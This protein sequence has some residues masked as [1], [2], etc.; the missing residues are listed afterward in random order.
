MLA[1]VEAQGQ[2]RLWFPLDPNLSPDEATIVSVFDHSVLCTQGRC[3]YDYDS[4]SRIIDAWGEE[5]RPT[6]GTVCQDCYEGEHAQAFLANGHYCGTAE[7]GDATI[8]RQHLCYNGHPGIDYRST[9]Y[10]H[11][12]GYGSPVYAAASGTLHTDALANGGYNGNYHEV[13]IDHGSGLA[14]IYLHMTN[15]TVEPGHV[16][17]GQQIGVTGDAGAPGAPHLHF[18]VRRFV[19]GHGW[20]PVDPYGWQG[21][22]S[23]PYTRATNEYLWDNLKGRV[24]WHPSGTLVKQAASP[25]IYVIEGTHLRHIPNMD[26][27]NGN[28]YAT[29]QIV[30]ISTAEYEA[31]TSGASGCGIGADVSL[32]AFDAFFTIAGDNFNNHYLARNGSRLNVASPAIA[33][34]WGYDWGSAQVVQPGCALASLPW[35]GSISFRDGALLESPTH[36]K[37]AV[38]HGKLRQFESDAVYDAMGYR[39]SSAIQAT[40]SEIEWGQGCFDEQGEVITEALIQA[41]P[42]CNGDDI[43][44]VAMVCANAQAEPHQMLAVPFSARDNGTLRRVFLQVSSLA[45]QFWRTMANLSPFVA[46]TEVNGSYDWTVPDTLNGA[47]SIRLVAE[48][49][50]GNLNVAYTTEIMITGTPGSP[51]VP[52]LNDPGFYSLNPDYTIDWSNANNV[53]YYVLEEDDN[54]S[55]SSPAQVTTSASEYTFYN[56]PNGDFWFRVKAVNNN[57]ESGWSN[58]IDFGWHVNHPPWSPSQPSPAHAATGFSR[59]HVV[60]SWTGSDPDNDALQYQPWFGVSAN[61]LYPTGPFGDATTHAVMDSLSGGSTYYWQVKAWDPYGSGTIAT[62][63]LWSFTTAYEFPDYQ[64]SNCSYTGTFGRRDSITMSV[65]V[66]NIGNFDAPGGSVYWYWSQD[67]ASNGTALYP[68]WTVFPALA[69]GQSVVV[70]QT[71]RLPEVTVG[72]SYLIAVV[73]VQGVVEPVLTN[74]RALDEVNWVDTN[75]PLV[76]FEG[77][78]YWSWGHMPGYSPLWFQAGQTY[79]PSGQASD[80]AGIARFRW[81]FSRDNGITWHTVRPWEETP[82]PYNDDVSLHFDWTPAVADTTDAGRLKVVVIDVSGDS[83][84]LVSDSVHVLY[85]ANPSVTILSPNGGEVWRVGETHTLQWTAQ[86]WV[87]ASLHYSNTGVGSPQYMTIASLVLPPAT[88]YQ[89]TVPG[90]ASGDSIAVHISIDGHGGQAA[91]WSDGTF[92]ILPN[93][94]QFPSPWSPSAVL[95]SGVGG[96]SRVAM[97]RDTDGTLHLVYTRGTGYTLRYLKRSPAGNWSSETTLDSLGDSPTLVLPSPGHPMVVYDY[98]DYN[99]SMRYVRA[100]YFDGS[101]WQAPVSLDSQPALNYVQAVATAS[102]DVWAA[103][104]VSGYA[105]GRVGAARWSGG[106]WGATEQVGAFPSVAGVRIQ[107]L[108]QSPKILFAYQSPDSTTAGHGLATVSRIGGLWTSAAFI[109]GMASGYYVDGGYLFDYLI[110]ADSAE[111]LVCTRSLGG[112]QAQYRVRTGGIWGSI[113]PL[114]GTIYYGPLALDSRGWPSLLQNDRLTWRRRD[115][116]TWG[117]AV[118]LTANSNVGTRLGYVI[119]PDDSAY[120]AYNDPVEN[121]L[122]FSA[123]H[124]SSDFTPPQVSLLAPTGGEIKAMGCTD[125]VRWTASDNIGI[126]G[127]D[128]YLSTNSGRN[129]T[130]LAASAANTGSQSWIVPAVSSDSCLMKLIVHDTGG[131]TGTALSP[132]VFAIHDLSAPT[133]EFLAPDGG[134]HWVIGQADTIRWTASDNYTPV[135]SLSCDVLLRRTPS[136]DPEILTAGAHT[137]FVLLWTATGAPSPNARVVVR[138]RDRQG[139]E[140]T[141]SS[142]TYL[143]IMPANAAPL[144]PFAPVPVHASSNVM[145]PA[146][147]SW[148]GTDPDADHLSYHVWAGTDSINLTHVAGPTDSTSWASQGIPEGTTYFWRIEVHDPYHTVLGPIWKFTMASVLAGP[149]SLRGWPLGT[150]Q[151]RLAWRNHPTSA[152]MTVVEDRSDSL[153]VIAGVTS[154]DSS[155]LT[156]DNLPPNTRHIYRVYASNGV[157]LSPSSNEVVV[158]TG[159][160]PPRVPARPHPLNGTTNQPLDLTLRYSGGDEDPGDQVH[161]RLQFGTSSVP[162]VIDTALVDTFKAVS[163]LQNSR[164]IFWRVT[165]I[166]NQGAQTS[167][168]LWYFSTTS[169]T[170]PSAP[171]SVTAAIQSSTVV[172]INWTDVSQ[173]ESG[174]VIQRQD[175]ES[176]PFLDIGAVPANTVSLMDST[177][178]G[179]RAY[180]YR[181]GSWNS[182]GRSV[183]SAPVSAITPNT[184]PEIDPLPDTTVLVGEMFEWT[185]GAYD[186]DLDTLMF[187]DN[188]AM[189]DVEPSTGWIQFTPALSD[190]GIHNVLVSATDGHGGVMSSAATWTVL[191]VAAP[192]AV[193]DVVVTMQPDSVRLDWSPVLTDTSGNPI[194]DISYV[195]EMSTDFVGWSTV[196]SADTSNYALGR[197]NLPAKAFFRVRAVRTNRQREQALRSQSAPPT[198]VEPHQTNRE[199]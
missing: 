10:G 156:L 149:D 72:T 176:A 100:R 109:P 68:R 40:Q 185:V 160:T 187:T 135:D 121:C 30:T 142:Q 198:R 133:V 57:G 54:A 161:Y 5:A 97:A 24:A 174:F 171:Q 81:D 99:H 88:S 163:G 146:I 102:G 168:P 147:L 60:L 114:P 87:S 106:T 17:Q 44:P 118:S 122:K 136:S 45:S 94:T 11:P 77:N 111:H 183:Y 169:Q 2:V 144:P 143:T 120:L 189:F 4:D 1:A 137:P 155:G 152:V 195:I 33:R 162:P 56:H 26:V 184:S 197:T 154:V 145:A 69:I 193:N 35:G 32:D 96:V 18:E 181:A 182:A 112:D 159:N 172:Q 92:R 134:G 125:T 151:I 177:V 46:T 83:A 188:A 21:C 29:C 140:V 167:G 79:H 179:H 173:N 107:M 36:N 190:T 165:A 20:I 148:Q 82:P 131:N 37:Y 105:T 27:F 139:N 186:I 63:P 48:D 91:D 12:S 61:E 31:Y 64:A 28:R 22:G 16:T 14:S 98:N 43:P 65:T 86:N 93:S 191:F 71:V 180:Q 58:V 42:A 9:L 158:V 103:W 75:L 170:T 110:T 66:R 157:H 25:D 76:T 192:R 3:T 138:V 89:W 62:S 55:F 7:C 13:W 19:T 41:P 104:G 78:P 85:F 8:A 101:S 52:Q 115:N 23:D 119:T 127:V 130:L 67:S 124:L 95:A 153:W 175:G 74:N 6:W 132:T 90:S 108:G 116:V 38:E 141:D 47:V 194:G 150:S 59:S 84:S 51:G 129:F 73:D 196:G 53:S 199:P 117:P 50:A 126:A 80:Q 34:S 15:I 128:I 113:E 49:G 166:D 39:R 164:F 70:S 123:A 178:R